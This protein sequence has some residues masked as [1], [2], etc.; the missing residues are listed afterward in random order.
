M[1]RAGVI[2]VLLER[3]DC[4]AKALLFVGFAI[5]FSA[6]FQRDLDESCTGLI[7]KANSLIPNTTM[8]KK[9]T[10]VAALAASLIAISTGF[11]ANKMQQKQFADA[12]KNGDE[13][14]TSE[15][16]VTLKGALAKK[17]A[18]KQNKEFKAENNKK[19][20]TKLFAKL[21]SNGDGKLNSD[22]FYASFAPKKK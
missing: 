18:E 3:N 17:R 1:K 19:Y 13:N 6:Q 21:D 2:L 11:A 20:L 12:D 14:I 5:R 16:F 10:L 7:S 8:M 15:E 9:T 22:E 4:E